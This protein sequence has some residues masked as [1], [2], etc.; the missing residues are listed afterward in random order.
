LS[1]KRGPF[2]GSS[3]IPH[4]PAGGGHPARNDK[5]TAGAMRHKRLKCRRCKAFPVIC[6]TWLSRMSVAGPNA[7]SPLSDAHTET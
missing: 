5:G 1:R 4:L 2:A 6:G 3:A 7:A